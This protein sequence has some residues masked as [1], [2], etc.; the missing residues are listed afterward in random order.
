MPQ[1]V[2]QDEQ[3]EISEKLKRFLDDAKYIFLKLGKGRRES[4]EETGG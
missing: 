4:Q 1:L 3:R 2:I